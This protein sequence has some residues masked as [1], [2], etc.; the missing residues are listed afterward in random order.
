M[1]MVRVSAWLF[2]SRQRLS[3]ALLLAL[4]AAAC[5]SREAPRRDVVDSGR[6]DTA[7]LDRQPS[8]PITGAGASFPY[9]LY[10]RWFNEYAPRA[11]SRINYLSIGSS[12]GIEAIIDHTVDFGATDVPM[13]DDELRRARTRI[14]H[15]PTA[16]GAVGITYNLPS[17]K[18]PLRLSG[19]VIAAIYLGAVTR[20][21]DSTLKALN[22][23]L[24][25]PDLPIVVVH[26]VDGSG[27]TWLLS[28]YLTLVS[29]VWAQRPGRGRVLEWPVGVGGSGNEGVAGEVKATLG[30]VGYVEVVYARQ[31]RLPVAHLRN[32]AGRFVSPL[33]FEIASAATAV[34]DSVGGA[35]LD[36]EG[37][38]RIS[39]ANAPGAQ[40]YPMAAFTFLLLDPDS[41]D[42]QRSRQIV[43]FLRWA[44][45]D[46]SAIASSLGYVPLPTAA[47]DRILQQLEQIIPPPK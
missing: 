17:L 18:R 33:P 23:D 2:G 26:R 9:P 5:T 34:L 1:R 21:N 40:A 22:P 10:A 6:A 41:A 11:N 19:E 13:T 47:A 46:G 30:G 27:T 43:E 20:W 25:L 4:C 32:R 39:L 7:S 15:V 35:R 36:R 14:L 42:R 31:N 12:A 8:S 24:E 28:D 3:A 38:F 16:I 29:P 37:G 44:Y 45:D